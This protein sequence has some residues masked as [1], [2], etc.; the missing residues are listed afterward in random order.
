[1]ESKITNLKLQLSDLSIHDKYQTKCTEFRLHVI[2]RDGEIADLDSDGDLDA[3][4]LPT[5]N[6]VSDLEL[7]EN[8]FV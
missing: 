4:T 8:H 7:K 3:L 5:E 6:L 2:P 1:M